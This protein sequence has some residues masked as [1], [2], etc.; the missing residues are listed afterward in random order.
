M[1]DSFL[2]V[3]DKSFVFNTDVF[4]VLAFRKIYNWNLLKTTGEKRVT[5]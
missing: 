4:S 2:D 5:H 3:P 1:Y